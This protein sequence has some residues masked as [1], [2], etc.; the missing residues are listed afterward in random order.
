MKIHENTWAQWAQGR[1]PRPGPGPGPGATRTG[2]RTRI[3][4]V[5]RT[6]T[7]T[8]TRPPGPGAGPGPGSRPGPGPG[9]GQGPGPGRS[10]F[11]SS[12]DS[13]YVN[14]MSRTAS[15]IP[16][17][18]MR[19]HVLAYISIH[20]HNTSAEYYPVF[21]RASPSPPFRNGGQND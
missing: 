7:G 14:G 12:A 1:D 2:T 5:T 21:L 11:N 3:G 16:Y 19:Q 17:N 20:L 15:H 13:K 4:T 6:R 9:K 18:K 10:S 8:G